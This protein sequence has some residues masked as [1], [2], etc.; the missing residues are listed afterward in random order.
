MLA[1]GME[2]GL[3]LSESERVLNKHLE[4]AKQ[5]KVKKK[6]AALIMLSTFRNECMLYVILN[7]VRGWE[8]RMYS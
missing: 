7:K 1:V 2:I 3:Y 8:F 5:T 4:L 6:K